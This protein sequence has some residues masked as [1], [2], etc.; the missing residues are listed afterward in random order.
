MNRYKCK[1]CGGNQYTSAPD[2]ENEPC[3][4]CGNANTVL[5][6]TLDEKPGENEGSVE[7]D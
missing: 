2:R 3:I 5:M 7:D 4:Y 6:D 1:N